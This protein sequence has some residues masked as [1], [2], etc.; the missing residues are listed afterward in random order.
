MSN[1]I[2]N[3]PHIASRLTSE[4][5]RLRFKQ[6]EFAELGGVSTR[7]LSGYENGAVIPDGSFLIAIATLGADLQYI[8]TGVRSSDLEAVTE[9]LAADGTATPSIPNGAEIRRLLDCWDA[10]PEGVR[11]QTVALLEEFAGNQK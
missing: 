2:R 7:S 11:T 3:Y 10:L 5:Q 4:R 6:A 1:E 8:L 9:A